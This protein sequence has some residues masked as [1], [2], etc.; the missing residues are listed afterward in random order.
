[1]IDRIKT[2]RFF[3]AAAAVASVAV[4][5]TVSVVAGNDEIIF[6]EAAALLIGFLVGESCPWNASPV[7]VVCVMV[8][9]ACAGVALVRAGVLLGLPL[10][11]QLVTGYV[12][13]LL[14]LN[15]LGSNMTPALSA[16][17]LP[18]IRHTTSLVY[19]CV[20]AV[21][22][23]LI[24]IARH[25]EMFY[26]REIIAIK[27]QIVRSAAQIIIF[28]AAA[29]V[30]VKINRILLVAPPVVVA[31]TALSWSSSFSV[32][33]RVRGAFMMIFAAGFGSACRLL[34]VPALVW[35]GLPFSVFFVVASVIAF[36]VLLFMMET[37]HS[38]FAPAGAALLLAFLLPVQTLGF[39]P[40]QAAAGMCVLAVAAFVVAKFVFKS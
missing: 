18:V 36:A 21:I 10:Y 15:V 1:M 35:C 7:H 8:V 6:P 37:A 22:A 26:V 11:A 2:L 34:A 5:M 33:Q 27:K 23:A 4:M 31:F 13:V 17:L 19:P 9:S 3:R 28:S 16:C 38:Y 20:V 12:F 39:Y 32:V 40:L 14:M 30:S 29:F 25:D 24:V